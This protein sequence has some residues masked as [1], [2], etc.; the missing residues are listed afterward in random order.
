MIGT[1]RSAAIRSEDATADA[2]AS[3]SLR[4]RMQLRAAGTR[5]STKLGLNGT[6]CLLVKWTGFP[7]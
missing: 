3:L 6:K 4:H 2:R 1:V 7:I 5:C